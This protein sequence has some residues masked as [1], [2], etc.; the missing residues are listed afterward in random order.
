MSGAYFYFASLSRIAEEFN[1]DEPSSRHIVQVLRMKNGDSLTLTDG[2]GLRAEARILEAHKK[3]CL[4]R[5]SDKLQKPQD[6]RR[7]TVAL[8]L[9]KNN[10]RFE[11]FL[12]K[13]TELGIGEIIPLK[14][15]RT[16]KQQFRKD[17]MKSIVE[18]A[19]VQ[20]QQCWMPELKDPVDFPELIEQV[21]ADQKFIAH[22]AT[23]E[24]RQLSEMI[25]TTLS[26]QLIL[27]G[28][29]G[30]FTDEEIQLAIQSRFIAVNLGDHRLRSETA[31]V[32]ASAI[33]KL[34]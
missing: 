11:W 31:A 23:G 26:S 29:E 14:C 9:L 20:S 17:R 7:I 16:E 4:V 15:S 32:A 33:L 34:I 22:C 5:I 27:V 25:N 6:P 8:S 13:A 18:S 2:R 1:L 19:L 30:D 10:N 12:E 24:R 21:I 28:P 3:R